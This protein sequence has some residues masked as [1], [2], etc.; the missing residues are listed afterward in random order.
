[1]PVA[2][3][4]TYWIT[5]LCAGGIVAGIG[6]FSTYSSGRGSFWDAFGLYAFP[7]PMGLGVTVDLAVL[8]IIGLLVA[9]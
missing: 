5:S 4:L 1:M 9:D 6:H 3:T 2:R 7:L 8:A